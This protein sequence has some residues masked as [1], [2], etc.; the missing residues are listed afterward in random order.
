MSAHWTTYP[1]AQT[2]AEKCGDHILSLLIAAL[3]G[4]GNATLAVSGG[5]TP[6]RMFQHMAKQELDWTRV[7]LFF[8]DE[9]AVPPDH[10]QS[11]YRMIEE[12]LIAPAGIPHR[13]VHRVHA[14]LLPQ[15]AALQVEADLRDYFELKAGEVPHFDVI[16]L[17][18]GSDAHTASLFPG[19]ELIDNRDGLAAAVYVS[20][21]EQ[22]R[23]TL[24][25]GVILAA[26]HLAL[27]VA[28]EDKAPALRSVL[29]GSYSPRDFP[30]QLC[31]HHARRS[32]W[33]LDVEAAKLL[34]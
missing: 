14:E 12:C 13:N 30:A 4:E 3:S 11:N 34:E 10:P 20:K 21:L 19:E 25:P 8:V 31:A 15:K 22:W 28:G 5:S 17:G 24:L 27:L 6:Q 2:T 29:Q 23:I 32:T 26:R 33:F 1:D 7:Q 16:H 9:R 18:M